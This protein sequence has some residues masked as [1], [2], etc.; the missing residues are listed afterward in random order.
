MNRINKTKLT[1]EQF[2]SHKYRLILEGATV[3]L[4]SGLLVSLFRLALE[5]AESLRGS[6]LHG[7]QNGGSGLIFALGL[8]FFAYFLPGVH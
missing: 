2:E 7:A 1:L 8:L 3:G 5:K 4:L 6:V